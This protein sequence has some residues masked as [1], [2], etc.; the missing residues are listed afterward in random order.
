M[1]FLLHLDERL[2]LFLNGLHCS[3]VDGF[4][5]LVSTKTI[6]IPL[7][8]VLIFFMIWKRKK[9]WW[10]TILSLALMILLSDQGSDLIKDTVQRFRPTHNPSIE[11]LVHTL[12][13]S[14]GV[15]YRGG[16]FGFVSSHAAN[17][18]AITA[19]VS[20]FFAKRWLTIFMICWA[21][22]I[23]YSRIY[24]GVHYPLDVFC[25]GFLGAT[26]GIGIFYLERFAYQRV[27]SRQP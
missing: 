25:G 5:W 4:M 9:Y 11:N 15:E 10:V 27:S 21:A 16:D 19:F 23:C 8:L 13:G 1:E 18:F 26:V 24:L 14:N 22:I 17:S 20:L 12:K 6:W 3:C 7:Y 2:F